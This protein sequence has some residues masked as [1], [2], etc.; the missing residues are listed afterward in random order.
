MK[1]I[2]IVAKD[3]DGVVLGYRD[4]DC[5]DNAKECADTFDD[6]QLTKYCVSA[7]IIEVQGELRNEARGAATQDPMIKLL[8]KATPAQK[9]AIAKAMAELG[10]K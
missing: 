1:K 10:V 4:V 7:W 8:K 9:A 3:K 2:T 5:P 6:K